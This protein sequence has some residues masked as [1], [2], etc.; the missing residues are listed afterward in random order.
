MENVLDWAK[1]IDKSKRN[2]PSKQ[3][4]QELFSRIHSSLNES[5]ESCF[6][7]LQA[8]M[9]FDKS[10]LE[11]FYADYYPQMNVQLQKKWDASLERWANGVK[12]TENATIRI[13]III[14]KKLQYV[15]DASSL[16][17]ELRWLSL[18]D[19]KRSIG[20]FKKMRDTVAPSDLQK[21]L[22]LDTTS[23]NL[24]NA[25]IRKMYE[26]IFATSE[27][28][29][30]K[31]MYTEFL[32]RNGW[33]EKNDSETL[34]DE[35]PAV[36]DTTSSSVATE[37]PKPETPSASPTATDLYASHDGVALAEA[38]L[39]WSHE[40]QDLLHRQTTTI[41]ELRMK[42]QKAYAQICELTEQVTALKSALTNETKKREITENTLQ[43]AQE[44]A[45]KLDEEKAQAL[46]TIERVQQMAGNSAKQELDGFR[47]NLSS[48]LVKTVKD[49]RD[50]LSDLSD[51]E[52]AEVY[53]T[54]FD[55]LI[56]TLK[57]HGIQIEV[58]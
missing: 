18:H 33:L 37:T 41:T 47:H 24:G 31:Q 22:S 34:N 19:D 17:E 26:I 2:K 11:P 36:N 3:S 21:L 15:Q 48:E 53:K 35:Q 57:H 13:A 50:D 51:A 29:T 1:S 38:L 6:V 8:L 27:D 52:R 45:A 20:E 16:L 5:D 58:N 9:K 14:C 46:D 7:C 54:L 28:S 23:L 4:Q 42:E 43:V 39:K 55:E 40:Q 12:P 25:Q 56:D 49:F 32:V 10:V 44:R 30:T